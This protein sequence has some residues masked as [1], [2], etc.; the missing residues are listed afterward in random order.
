[1]STNL[2]A[3]LIALI[4]ALALIYM[5]CAILLESSG[6]KKKELQITPKGIVDH[7]KILYKQKKY[8]LVEKLAKKYLEIKP[9]HCELRLILAKA[10]YNEDSIYDA[11]KEALTILNKEENNSDARLLLAMCYK[12]VNQPTKAIS[13]LQEI[14]KTDPDN[15]SAAQE[16]SILYVE[17]NQKPSAIK[18]L[19]HL[20]TL[21]DNNGE[22][23]QIKNA[24]NV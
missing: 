10:L 5:I 20:E 15:M 9:E 6:P 1:M 22:L 17:T 3:F 2:L 11:V 21:T 4:S 7:A 16:L 8:K 19:K 24:N 12:K 23:L 14:L 18:S 13:E